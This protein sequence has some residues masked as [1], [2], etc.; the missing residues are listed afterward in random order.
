M[1]DLLLSE[2]EGKTFHL[3]Y[4]NMA[5]WY[6]HLIFQ[7]L[8]ASGRLFPTVDLIFHGC[9]RLFF[10]KFHYCCDFKRRLFS[11]NFLWTQHWLFRHLWLSFYTCNMKR[12]RWQD[13]QHPLY[14]FFDFSSF[15]N[16]YERPTACSN[17]FYLNAIVHPD[18]VELG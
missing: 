10:I 5:L 16:L 1:G 15:A 11:Q 6:W 17:H 2:N 12:Q 8:S 18:Y 7:S 13:V 9:I 14:L 4:F 3:V